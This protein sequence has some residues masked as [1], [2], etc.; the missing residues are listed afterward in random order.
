LHGI[1]RNAW[2]WVN[3]NPNYLYAKLFLGRFHG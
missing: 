3:A 2:R 1:P